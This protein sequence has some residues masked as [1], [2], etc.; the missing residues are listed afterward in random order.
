MNFLRKVIEGSR[1][2]P[3]TVCLEALNQNFKNAINVEWYELGN[4]FEAI[5][6]KDNLEHI[7]LFNT[8]GILQ[9]YTQYLPEGYLPESIKKILET[10]G[11][12]MNT[13]L[14]NKGNTIE[15][16]VIYRD[17]ELNRYLMSFSDTGKVLEEKKL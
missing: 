8:D 12:V 10:R 6:Y 15:Y 5:F 13:V 7:A 11:E 2:T 9:E 14:K 1:I 16:E 17:K 4:L 3:T